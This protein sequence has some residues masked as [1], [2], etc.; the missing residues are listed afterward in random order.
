MPP[1]AEKYSFKLMGARMQ[2]QTILLSSA[3]STGGTLGSG[4]FST[5]LAV[6]LQ[7]D[8]VSSCKVG[9]FIACTGIADCIVGPKASGNDRKVVGEFRLE[10]MNVNVLSEHPSHLSIANLPEDA[11]IL[12]SDL[13]EGNLD[14]ILGA[15]KAW[16]CPASNQLVQ[17]A[18][19]LSACCAGAAIPA[20]HPAHLGPSLDYDCDAY[21]LS[22]SGLHTSFPRINVLLLAEEQDGGVH[23]R[24]LHTLAH[25]LS[26]HTTDGSLPGSTLLPKPLSLPGM[27]PLVA[28]G[29]LAEANSGICLLLQGLTNKQG[30][31]VGESLRA[32]Q[33]AVSLPGASISINIPVVPTVWC[34]AGA[35]PCQ[36]STVGSKRRCGGQLPP[37]PAA[38][39]ELSPQFVAPFDVILD[40]CSPDDSEI[41]AWADDFLGL[42]T[43]GPQPGAAKLALQNHITTCQQM[44]APR[45]TT[46]AMQLLSGYWNALRTAVSSEGGVPPVRLDS[47]AMLAAASARLCHRDLIL[48]FPDATLAIALCEEG[49]I[50][51]GWTSA[52]WGPLWEQMAAGKGLTEC[53]EGLYEELA[54][55]AKA[56]GWGPW[57]EGL[58]DEE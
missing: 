30:R 26:T 10:A 54:G 35:P 13:H 47:A 15:M 12:A 5:P 19:L 7:D 37:G 9:D 38:F 57:E 45:M 41:E 36:K 44:P 29:Q 43:M 56:G 17:A 23:A 6:V 31:A 49:L 18:L 22:R 40:C 42:V 27:P 11:Q 28:A 21:M 24:M 20:E 58:R 16:A 34:I 14:A 8:L 1:Y 3:T 25:A 53:L 4:K 2:A 55:V 48:P 51:Q 39:A 46:P 52:L 50:A 32:A 33:A